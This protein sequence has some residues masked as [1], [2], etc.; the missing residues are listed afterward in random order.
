MS[1]LSHYNNGAASRVV[2]L[3]IAFLANNP[4]VVDVPAV[5]VPGVER[6]TD[7]RG[8]KMGAPDGQEEARLMRVPPQRHRPHIGDSG[9]EV[10]Q[11]GQPPPLAPRALPFPL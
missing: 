1:S 2:P 5:H 4:G 10:V 7:I 9:P 6:P 11:E 3:G 8:L